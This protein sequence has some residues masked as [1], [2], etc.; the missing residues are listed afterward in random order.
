MNTTKKIK[1]VPTPGC[2][3]DSTWQLLAEGN[4][5]PIAGLL[6]KELAL[7]IEWRWNTYT[8]LDDLKN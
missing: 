5:K 2:Y 3:N 4:P 1:A 7:E 6:T 8:S